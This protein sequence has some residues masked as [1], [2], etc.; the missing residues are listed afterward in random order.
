MKHTSYRV[1]GALILAVFVLAA[2]TAGATDGRGV[3]TLWQEL[4][5]GWLQG[6]FVVGAP[7]PVAAAAEGE[8]GPNIDPDG[9]RQDDPPPGADAGPTIEPD[10][11]QQEQCPAH[12][13]GGPGIDPHG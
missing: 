7:A 8:A 1:T 2:P 11:L 6:L 13:E 5:A 4:T 12:S 10:G 3:A 9:L